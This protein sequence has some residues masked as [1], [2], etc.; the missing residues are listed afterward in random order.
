MRTLSLCAVLM[1][2]CTLVGCAE[3]ASQQVAASPPTVSYRVAGAN[4]S[5]ANADAGRYCGQYGMAA[6]LNGTPPDGGGAVANYSCVGGTSGAVYG[7]NGYYAPSTYQT[8]VTQYPTYSQA[9]T[10]NPPIYGSSVQCADALHQNR[11]GGS[12]YSGPPVAGC[13]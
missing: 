4:L 10:Y 2:A 8:P 9:P 11:P 12:D 7:S 6:Q 1:A 3:T 5:Q 13:P